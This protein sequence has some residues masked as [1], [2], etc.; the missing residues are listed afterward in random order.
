[1]QALLLTQILEFLLTPLR[2]GRPPAHILPC[3]GAGISTHAPAGG[4]TAD[5][6]RA[7][8]GTSISTHAPAGGATHVSPP[9]KARRLFLLTPLREG[10]HVIHLR[11]D[12][13][14][15]ISTHA[16]AGGATL[17]PQQR[18]SAS[19]LFL[20]TPLREGR[21]PLIVLEPFVAVFLLTPLREGRRQFSTIPS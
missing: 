4:A 2:E 14:E 13:Y 16:P 17:S 20:L 10:R 12:F 11:G 8:G 21:L 3:G 7:K 18:R 1:M 6:I 15:N 5:A 9:K 19:I